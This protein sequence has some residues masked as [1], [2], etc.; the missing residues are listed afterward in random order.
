MGLWGQAREKEGTLR[1]YHGSHD[2]MTIP[3]KHEAK[4]PKFYTTD[5]QTAL[6]AWLTENWV[7]LC[8]KTELSGISWIRVL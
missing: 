6:G 4:H 2:I 1:C 8:N 7:P 3:R 5:L